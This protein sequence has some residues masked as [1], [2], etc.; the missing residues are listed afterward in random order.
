M[1]WWAEIFLE[2]DR[3]NSQW[4]RRATQKQCACVV[5]DKCADDAC[6]SKE[7]IVSMEDSDLLWK[8]DGEM[9][10]AEVRCHANIPI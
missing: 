6:P 5:S 7:K 4:I 3:C 2:K 1:N 8:L 9:Q 10:V